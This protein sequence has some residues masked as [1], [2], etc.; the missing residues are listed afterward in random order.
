MIYGAIQDAEPSNPQQQLQA[1]SFT[2]SLYS[3]VGIGAL[4]VTINS[5]IR[6]KLSDM[7]PIMR[8]LKPASVGALYTISDTIMLIIL[9]LASLSDLHSECTRPVASPGFGA[10]KSCYLRDTARCVSFVLADSSLI[11]GQKTVRMTR[12]SR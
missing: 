2:H 9:K 5:R 6:T 11:N 12:E 10:R 4:A 3:I 8:L 1:V 7:Q